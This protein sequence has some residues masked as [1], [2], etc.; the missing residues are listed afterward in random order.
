MCTSFSL[1]SVSRS[2]AGGTHALHESLESRISKQH[3]RRALIQPDPPDDFLGDGEGSS[4][5]GAGGVDDMEGA[6]FLDHVKILEERAVAGHGLG[7]DAG[8]AGREML[9]ADFGDEFLEGLSEEGFAEGAAAF[10]PDHRG[11]AAEEIPE[12]GEG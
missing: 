12:A 8:A 10:V 2:M 11:V 9:G 4:G 3:R 6:G 5:G 7:A 1:A